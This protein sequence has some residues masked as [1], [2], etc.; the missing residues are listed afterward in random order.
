[1]ALEQAIESVEA[2]VADASDDELVGLVEG[3]A[4]GRSPSP[5]YA[6]TL[7]RLMELL[8]DSAPDRMAGLHA[9]FS[10]RNPRQW[11]AVA[12][13]LA[14]EAGERRRAQRLHPAGARKP[15]VVLR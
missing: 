8:W 14:P 4:P 7:D 2:A 1:M 12:N 11:G 13:M 3:F 10:E 6:S 15:A 9:E 5:E